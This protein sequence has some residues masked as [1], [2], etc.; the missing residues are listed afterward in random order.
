MGYLSK[1]VTASASYLPSQVTE[2]STRSPRSVP[3]HTEVTGVS[4]AVVTTL[5]NYRHSQS[6]RLISLSAERHLSNSK[7]DSG[8][9]FVIDD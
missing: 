2:V 4:H 6:R 1:A 8:A 7:A 3:G 5:H 9:I